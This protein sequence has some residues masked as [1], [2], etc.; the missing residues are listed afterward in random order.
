LTNAFLV[1]AYLAYNNN[2]QLWYPYRVF[3]A[4]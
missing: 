1:F 4:L 3:R 2:K